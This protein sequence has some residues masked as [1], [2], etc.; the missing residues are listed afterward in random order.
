MK[1]AGLILVGIFLCAANPASAQFGIGFCEVL[2]AVRGPEGTRQVA[3]S[4]DFDGAF[5]KSYL[6][7]SLPSGF[8]SFAAEAMQISPSEFREFS[9]LVRGFSFSGFEPRCNWAKRAKHA[10]QVMRVTRPLSTHDGKL[11]ILAITWMST[12]GPGGM[13]EMCSLRKGDPFWRARCIGTWVH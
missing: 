4:T 12:S 10:A 5:L 13:G 7:G 6:D 8:R 1:Y 3:A 9:A 11:Q 2:D